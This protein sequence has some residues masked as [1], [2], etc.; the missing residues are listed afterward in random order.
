[1]RAVGIVL[2][3]WILT[4]L[5]GGVGLLL[6]SL[7]GASGSFGGAVLGG[8]AGVA[9]ATELFRHWR[10]LAAPWD[11]RARLVGLIAFCLVAPLAGMV[12]EDPLAAIGL[13][14]LVGVGML[15]G[16]RGGLS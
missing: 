11:H 16:G 5:G 1:M 8:V 14:S 7:A 6:G 15:L 13:A 9:G 3:G 12:R 2:T 10:W 4:A